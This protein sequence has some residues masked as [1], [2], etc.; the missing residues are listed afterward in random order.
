[1]ENLIFSLRATMPVFI[2][3]MLGILLKRLGIFDD[4]FASKM[5]KFV[6][7][8]PLPCLL[9][10]Q[11]SHID[12]QRAWNGPFVLFCFVS[13]AICIFVAFLL[14]LFIKNKSLTLHF[15]RIRLLILF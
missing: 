7:V 11:L 10:S 15:T 6:F 9:F 5:N 1:M 13:T 12:F 14:S 3:M 4:S 2:M 8:V